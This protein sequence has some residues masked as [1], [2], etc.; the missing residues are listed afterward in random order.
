[1]ATYYTGGTVW[2]NWNASSYSDCTTSS[3]SDTVW[4]NWNT[5]STTS[6]YLIYADKTW[7]QWVNLEPA[8]MYHATRGVEDRQ[9][10]NEARRIISSQ[11]EQGRQEAQRRYAEMEAKRIK[12]EQKALQ[13]VM[14]LIGEEQ[15]RIYEQT[16]NLLVKGERYDWLLKRE[17]KV[18]RVEKDKVSL[19]CIHTENGHRSRQP[20]TD[21]VIS[22]ALNAKF[23]EK[24]MEKANFVSG[25]NLFQMPRAAVMH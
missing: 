4:D 15:A 6:S 3:T 2:I 18:Y 9:I 8:T 17:G 5:V 25:H 23:N 12:A 21:N 22:L 13:L 20:E 24:E 16:G 10:E 1:M 7:T 19:L 11:I 14:D